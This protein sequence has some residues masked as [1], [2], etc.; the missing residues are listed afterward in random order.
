MKKI[1]FSFKFLMFVLWS[2]FCIYIYIVSNDFKGIYVFGMVGSLPLSYIGERII[3]ILN[4]TRTQSLF[5]IFLV[6][7]IQWITVGYFID[8]MIKNIKKRKK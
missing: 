2:I 5:V 8:K 7:S 3:N 6:G 4:A 1:I